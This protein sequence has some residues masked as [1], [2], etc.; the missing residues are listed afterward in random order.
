LTLQIGSLVVCYRVGL[1]PADYASDE[2]G[3]KEIDLRT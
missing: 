2:V 1:H 3:L